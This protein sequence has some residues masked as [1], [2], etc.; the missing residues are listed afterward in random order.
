[1]M[2]GRHAVL[3]EPGKQGSA[4]CRK[5]ANIAGSRSSSFTQSGSV[6]KFYKMKRI[7]LFLL[8]FIQVLTMTGQ[9]GQA[10]SSWESLRSRPYPAWFRDAKLGIFIHWS[11][12]SV[13]AWSG[14]EQYAE[15][16]LRGL[17]TGDSARIQFQEKV[18]GE[19]FTYNDYAPLFKGELFDAGEWATLFREAGA[20]YVVLVSK[21]HDGYC[22]WPSRYAKGWNSVETGPRRDIVGELSQAVRSEGLKMGL[23]YSLPEWNNELYHWGTDP[24]G[25]VHSYVDEHMIPQFRELITTYKPSLLFSDGEWDHPASTW[26]AAELISWYYQEVGEEAIVNDRWG[27]GSEGVGFRTPEYSSGT[28]KSDRPWAEVR[29][30][31]RSFGLNRNEPL[32]AYMSPRDLVHFFVKAVANGGGMILNVGPYCDGQIP[33]LQQERLLQLGSWLKVN[34]EAIYGS[35]VAERSTEE[36]QVELKRID[37]SIDFDWVRNSP[38]KPI[39]EDDFTAEWT[40]FIQPRYSEEYTFE[41]QADDKLSLWINNELLIEQQGDSPLTD[42]GNVMEAGKGKRL[43]GKMFLKEGTRYAI[44]LEYEE[45]KQNAHAILRWKSFSQQ[46]EVVPAGCLFTGSEPSA[47]QGLNAIYRSKATWLCYT[48]NHGN[49]YAIALEW[50][51]DN[52]L[53]LSMDPPQKG[54]KVRLLGREGDLPWNYN[55]GKMQVDINSVKITELPCEHAW[56]F[57]IVP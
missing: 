17:M 20:R 25:K 56:V 4:V 21:H 53:V 40:G 39:S 43:D 31:G 24:P 30:L 7:A 49:L 15:W 26:H 2:K 33:L 9:T 48:R 47:E 16:F 38:G 11:L 44:R 37:P 54:T 12:S 14:K 10:E 42:Q 52:I 18:F 22:L 41:V 8:V 6:I 32:E 36:K 57:S 28:V 3:F 1:M 23:Y 13:P 51:R 55:E 45:S 46:S 34:G 5:N 27:S 29:G 35:T 50:P 19:E